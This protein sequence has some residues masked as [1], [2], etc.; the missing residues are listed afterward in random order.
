MYYPSR[1]VQMVENGDNDVQ[2]L[3]EL[4]T[5]YREI[6]AMLGSQTQSQMERRF[7]HV[8]HIMLADLLPSA[9]TDIYITGDKGMMQYLFRILKRHV[10]ERLSEARIAVEDRRNVVI[11]VEGNFNNDI[12]YM[13]CRQILREHGEA[14]ANRA[15][16]LVRGE[17]VMELTLCGGE[18]TNNEQQTNNT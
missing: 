1:I 5:Y 3:D 7:L 8:R 4:V 2:T 17:G 6:Y 15:C 18:R 10:G 11:A 12:D 14:T 13:L 16:G 9:P